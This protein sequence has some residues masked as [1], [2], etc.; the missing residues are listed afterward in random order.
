ML[1]M[2]DGRLHP[3]IEAVNGS[4]RSRDALAALAALA[5]RTSRLSAHAAYMILGV[6]SASRDPR[7][8][9]C[10]TQAPSSID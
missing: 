9:M 5:A 4:D 1:M 3:S 10:C 2:R 6:V 8:G 7:S